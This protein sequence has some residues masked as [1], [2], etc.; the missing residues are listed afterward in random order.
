MLEKGIQSDQRQIEAISAIINEEK[1]KYITHATAI[2][3]LDPAIARAKH[4]CNTQQELMADLIRM[5]N[6]L[7]E[8]CGLNSPDLAQESS[9]RN[10]C[11]SAMTCVNA[12]LQSVIKTLADQN[13]QLSENVSILH[14]LILEM[15]QEMY[16]QTLMQSSAKE[17]IADAQKYQ[18][19]IQEKKSLLRSR[20]HSINSIPFEVLSII[21][22][23]RVHS[24]WEEYFQKP[25]TLHMPMTAFAL[26]HVCQLWR[27]V[28]QAEKALWHFVPLPPRSSLELLEGFCQANDRP[29]TIVY[30]LNT[31]RNLYHSLSSAQSSID[32]IAG[33]Q[34]YS[35][36]LICGGDTSISRNSSSIPFKN[37]TSLTVY[38][39]SPLRAMFFNT[40][41]ANFPNCKALEIVR[42]E[43]S[44]AVLP[45]LATV[46]PQLTSLRIDIT[47]QG[48]IS[49]IEC[50]GSNL[51]ELHIKHHG[52]E[53]LPPFATNLRLPKLKVLGLTFSDAAVFHSLELPTMTTLVLYG[54]KQ[55]YMA[56]LTLVNFTESPSFGSVQ[57]L[58]LQKWGQYRSSAGLIWG[59]T[60]PILEIVE[61]LKLIT[62][63]KFT[64]SFVDGNHMY[65]FCMYTDRGGDVGETTNYRLRK[66]VINGC[67][68]ITQWQCWTIGRFAGEL[69]VFL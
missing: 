17:H 53:A 14:R 47:N 22:A 60:H 51:M 3:H 33:L 16:A 29:K 25:T 9:A 39:C 34:P 55:A 69:E 30:D 10:A 23:L 54:P 40:L 8:S 24:D 20:I 67:N 5:E 48:S 52:T 32:R 38:L 46:F 66:I 42:C 50:L 15:T 36:K 64:D 58:E 59:V 28:A 1:E 27:R 41:L 61:K 7:R 56:P 57:T 31:P 37:P 19:T 4:A 45:P 26:A 65:N 63:L 2:A 44:T 43:M 35:L 18:D 13:T 6:K 62:T 68:G 12:Q 11:E 49:V 21:F